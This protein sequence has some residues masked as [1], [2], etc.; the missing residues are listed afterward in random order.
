M[1]VKAWNTLLTDFSNHLRDG[2]NR[3]QREKPICEFQAEI[4]SSSFTQKDEGK[5]TIRDINNMESSFPRHITSIV[6]ADEVK[7]RDY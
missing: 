2:I 1:L 3:M 7:T 5:A 6:K 4:N